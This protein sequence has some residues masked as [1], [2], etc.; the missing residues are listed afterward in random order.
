ME[1]PP[2]PCKPRNTVKNHDSSYLL[3][4]A[5]VMEILTSPTV[6][7]RINWTRKSVP[8]VSDIPHNPMNY[9]SLQM[10]EISGPDFALGHGNEILM[11]EKTL[12]ISK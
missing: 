12:E 8:E 5:D 1:K 10:I 2:C 6:N 11:M 9:N 7:A 3:N 4:Y